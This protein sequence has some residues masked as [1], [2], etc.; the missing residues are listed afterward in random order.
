MRENAQDFVNALSMI[1]GKNEVHHV[2]SLYPLSA[3]TN[4]TSND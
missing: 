1:D 2:D 3:R 4:I